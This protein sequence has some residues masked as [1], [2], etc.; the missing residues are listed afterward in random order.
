MSTLRIDRRARATRLPVLFAQTDQDGGQNEKKGRKR[1]DKRII[2]GFSFFQG[3][4][5]VT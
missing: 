4:R 3:F 2:G 5:G 1:R